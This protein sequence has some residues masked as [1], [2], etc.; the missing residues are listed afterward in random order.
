MK[1]NIQQNFKYDF[2]L[3]HELVLNKETYVKK[4][5]CGLVNIGNTC[6][7]NSILQCLSH[8]LKLTDYF[9]SKKFKED[10]DSSNKRKKEYK[11]LNSYLNLLINLWDTNQIIKPK[12]FLD[13]L[14]TQVQKY[15][16]L[17]QQD[18]HE[19]LM[20]ILDT[21]HKAMAYEVEVCISGDP[22]TEQD[23]LII[24]FIKKF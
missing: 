6:F 22:L 7:L 13:S 18:S 24:F 17:Q 5:L 14:S 3:N 9:L 15:S 4:G 11:L 16:R 19:C 21:L 8:S 23:Y 1:E 20:Y 10:D 2:H 12:T